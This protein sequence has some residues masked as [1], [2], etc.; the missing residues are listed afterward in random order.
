MRMQIGCL[1]LL[2]VFAPGSLLAQRVDLRSGV[3]EDVFLVV[4]AKHNPERNVRNEHLAQVWQ[5]VQ[6]TK[7]ID[8]VL[9]LITDSVSAQ[10]L[11]QAKSVMEELQT[12]VEPLDLTAIAKMEDGIYTQRMRGFANQQLALLRLGDAAD[13][14]EE[15]LTNLMR[16]VDKY[17]D[18]S[19][20][21]RVSQHQG[22]T[23]TA[24][25]VPAEAQM[26]P[27]VARLGGILLLS[28]SEDF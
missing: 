20:P 1:G 28:N 24:L 22:A 4:H 7:I 21:V 15:G 17:S 2:L 16:L 11:D 19:V 3:P 27:V 23:L 26:T 18:G 12:A 13:G 6:E 5:T 14:W 10:Q 9:K 8:K 25:A